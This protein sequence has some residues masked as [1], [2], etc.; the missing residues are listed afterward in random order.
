MRELGEIVGFDISEELRYSYFVM[1]TAL[2][3]FHNSYYV[4][5]T[6]FSFTEGLIACD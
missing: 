3:L 4:I 6:S 1:G 2:F 5:G